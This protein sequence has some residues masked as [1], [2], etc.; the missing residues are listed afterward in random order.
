MVNVNLFRPLPLHASPPRPLSITCSTVECDGGALPVCAQGV[1]REQRSVG[2]GL[3]Q[4]YPFSERIA[5]HVLGGAAQRLPVD[6]GDH[7]APRRPLATRQQRVYAAR[8]RSAAI[9]SEHKLW[10]GRREGEG[11][12]SKPRTGA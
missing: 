8:T 4:G 2:R 1:E 7:E 10:G 6:V 3:V 11:N 12:T 5:R 9:E